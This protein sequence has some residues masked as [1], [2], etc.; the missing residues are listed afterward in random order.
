LCDQGPDHLPADDIVAPTQDQSLLRGCSARGDPSADAVDGF[1]G[2]R[3]RVGQEGGW[4][5][6]ASGGRMI[7]AANA[8]PQ[9]RAEASVLFARTT[10]L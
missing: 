5:F 10:L 9:E 8:P 3:H 2:R 4:S 7:A 6:S 1:K